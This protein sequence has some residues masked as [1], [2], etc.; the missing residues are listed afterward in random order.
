MTKF[1]YQHYD[2]IKYNSVNAQQ[3]YKEFP[4]TFEE[5]EHKWKMKLFKSRKCRNASNVR[6]ILDWEL[7]D[8]EFFELRYK[9]ETFPVIYDKWG[10]KR[11]GDFL[12]LKGKL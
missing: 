6:K 11:Q 10:F 5:T 3:M 7:S 1:Y 9:A 12:N 4:P 8:D 2:N